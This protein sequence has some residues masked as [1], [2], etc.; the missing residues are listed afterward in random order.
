MADEKKGDAFAK[1]E[2]EIAEVE[3][4]IKTTQSEWRLAPKED[5][6]FFKGVLTALWKE[7]EQLRKEK[8]QLRKEKE[9]LR[10]KEILLLRQSA[11]AGLRCVFYLSTL[12]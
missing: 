10:E 5:K 12:P 9:Q 2:Q 8:E 11:P 6:E 7:K 4:E 3:K 1:V